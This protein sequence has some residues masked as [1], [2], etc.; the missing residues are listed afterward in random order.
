LGTSIHNKTG[1]IF[2]GYQAGYSEHGSNKLYIE[3]SA[4]SS[5]L[6]GGDFSANEIYLNGNV[7]I[8]SSLPTYPLTIVPGDNNRA[9]SIDH[10][11]TSPGATYS[12][13]VD[14]D[15][16]DP[17]NLQTYGISSTAT[18]TAGSSLTTALYGRADGDATGNK[19]G[20]YGFATGG[21]TYVHGVYGKAYNTD[22]SGI[23]YGVYGEAEGTGDRG[24]QGVRGVGI[25]E[26]SIGVYG[27]G[28]NAGLS[29]YGTGSSSRG[30]YGNGQLYDFYASGPGINYGSSSSIRWKR[31]I[32]EI[33]NP[34]QKV[35]KLRGVYFDW[36]EENGGHHDVGCIAEEVGA[37]LPEIVEYEENGIDA[38]GMD[39][40]KLT[41]LLLE[42]IK[43]QQEI[44][45]GQ[46]KRIDKLEEQ[47]KNLIR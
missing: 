30:V 26:N 40:S 47:I 4:G 6:I 33:D 46:N 1:N 31:N 44:I 39:Y 3:N 12:I 19:Y 42:A 17:G 38:E 21:G 27:T 15:N 13:H 32:Q 35:S 7:G 22:G 29:G 9:I 37:V 28:E 41:P 25:G 11:Q 5:P 34:L 10:D 45:N 16:T 20:V 36:D 24:K 43:A 14:L 23:Y 8:R 18:S 2:L